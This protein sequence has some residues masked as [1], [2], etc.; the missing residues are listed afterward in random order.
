MQSDRKILIRHSLDKAEQ[1]LLSAK[2]NIDNDWLSD[3]QNRLYYAIFY[4]VLALG[5]LEGFITGKHG[6]LRGWFNK[7]FIYEDKI[8]DKSL[9]VIY[10]RL[11]K[12][13]MLFDYTVYE[14][15]EK[16][17][18]IEDLADAKIFVNELK[19][20]ILEKIESQTND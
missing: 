16:S 20:Y 1:A 5:Y 8:F 12:N 11:Y 13:R 2:M 19:K 4:C 9:L 15:P 7:K 18:A 17:S 10:N 14:I 6:Q 3:A